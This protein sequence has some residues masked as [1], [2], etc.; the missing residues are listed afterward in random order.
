MV[1][2]NLLAI[3]YIYD[4]NTLRYIEQALYQLEKYINIFR[5]FRLKDDDG[6]GH[7]NF[8][9]IHALSY[10]TWS[11]RIYRT[12]KGVD[13]SY[14]ERSY[15]H[16]IKELYKRTNKRKGFKLY[17][18]YVNTRYVNIITLWDL[19]IYLYT[20]AGSQADEDS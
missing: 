2:F 18:L 13:T 15:I 4:N 6:E 3:Y 20:L 9:K 8:A 19:I 17:I 1:D 10:Y 16:I 7:F 12:V 14:F 11:I 5:D